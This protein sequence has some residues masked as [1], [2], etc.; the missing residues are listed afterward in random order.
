VRVRASE[1]NGTAFEE[2]ATVRVAK[3]VKV[4]HAPKHADGLDLQGKTGTVVKN[5]AH[6]K[7]KV[8]S[9]NLPY[10]VQFTLPGSEGKPTKF[11][12]HLVRAMVARERVGAAAV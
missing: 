4:F 5:V 6:Y 9:P 12:V 7:D 10:K 2:G 8:L 11:F 1:D 3:E